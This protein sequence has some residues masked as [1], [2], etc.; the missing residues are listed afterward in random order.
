MSRPIPSIGLV[1]PA[2]D[3]A[4]ALP[5][6]LQRVPTGIRVVVADNDS[7]DRT[8]AVAAE[9]GALVVHAPRRGYGEA[10]CQGMAALALDPPDI[11]VVI[12]ADGADDP[13][14]LPQLIAP[15]LS[16]E[17]DIALARRLAAP[18]AL[19]PAQRFGNGLATRLIAWRTGRRYRDLG[20]FR[21]FTWDAWTRLEIEDRTWGI[22]VEAQM[23][24]VRLGLRTVEVPLPYACRRAG[25]SKIS[26]ELKGAARAGVRILAAVHRYG[27]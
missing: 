11:A 13:K 2:R 23:K 4:Q 16:G 18:A 27:G 24:A 15:I 9:H 7:R 19:T 17:A 25:Q 14:H 5:W 22:H 3:E 12:D 21:A 10:M 26:G 8:A 1:I 6:V 20:P